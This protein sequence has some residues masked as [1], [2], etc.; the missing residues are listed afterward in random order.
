M[1]A[2]RARRRG[3]GRDVR[4]QGADGR[5]HDARRDALHAPR[6]PSAVSGGEGGGLMHGPTFMA[7][8]LACAVALASL[9][10]LAERGWRGAGRARS[11]RAC[12]TGS[13]RR[14]SCPGVADVRV[15]GAIGVIELDAP[16]DIAGAT[17]RRGRARRVAAAVPRP[18]LRDA[19]LRDRREDLAAV[20]D[21]R[22]G[23]APAAARRR[24]RE[25]GPWRRSGRL[26][27]TSGDAGRAP[28]SRRP[29]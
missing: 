12:A 20:C 13:R 8:P 19:A 6:S 9:D 17:R 29:R 4:R 14:A 11:R 24:A 10:L 3:A 15:L 25:R 18:H 1:F 26:A 16:V 2:A 23:R 5:L 28:C 7:N 27:G 22:G 21:A